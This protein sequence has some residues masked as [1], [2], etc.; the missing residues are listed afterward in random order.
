VAEKLIVLSDER[1]RSIDIEQ[2]AIRVFELECA[3]L[4]A[5]PD[6]PNRDEAETA[7]LRDFGSRLEASLLT[8]GTLGGRVEAASPLMRINYRLP[9]VQYGD[10]T[11]GRQMTAEFPVAESVQPEA[12]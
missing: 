4:T 3:F 10:G 11:R 12:V 7:Q 2:T 8:D 6:E 1:F 9:F 5:L